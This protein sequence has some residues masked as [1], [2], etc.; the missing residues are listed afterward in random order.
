MAAFGLPGAVAA[1]FLVAMAIPKWT[2]AAARPRDG[3]RAVGLDTRR[4]FV[5]FVV[6][7]G[8]LE[9]DLRPLVK[10]DNPAVGIVYPQKWALL[11]FDHEAMAVREVQLNLPQSLSAVR[12]ELSR[13][14]RL[15]AAGSSLATTRPTA[16]R[17][18]ASTPAAVAAASLAN[19]SA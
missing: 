9:A 14:R 13:S 3:H 10:P 18:P 12:R 4:G 19:C 6:R 2:A 8:R 15:P 11:L 16:T 7:G 5:T 17:S 1:L